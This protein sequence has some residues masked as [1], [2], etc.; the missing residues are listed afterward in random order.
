MT[1]RNNE[2]NCDKVHT[3]GVLKGIKTPPPP[4][5]GSVCL[6]V[7]VFLLTCL[8]ERSV[9]YDTPTPW[10]K[11]LTTTIVR[12]NFWGG[13]FIH[14]EEKILVGAPPPPP[15]PPPPRDFF[16]AG[17]V[18]HLPWNQIL[19]TSLTVK[20]LNEKHLYEGGLKMSFIGWLRR[21]CAIA[22]KLGMH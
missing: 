9:R 7:F 20:Y 4:P 18:E 13:S 16:R 3:Q 1:K 8:S 17:V 14:W 22:M 19:H 12:I 11:I 2:L 5:F 15:P 6:I 10:C 21:S